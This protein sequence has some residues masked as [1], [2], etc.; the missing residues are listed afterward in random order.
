MGGGVA[1]GAEGGEGLGGAAEFADGGGSLA[2]GLTRAKL[3]TPR[4]AVEQFG[5]VGGEGVFRCEGVRAD[6]DGR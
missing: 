3:V 5:G 4:Q 6:R 2:L 1:G